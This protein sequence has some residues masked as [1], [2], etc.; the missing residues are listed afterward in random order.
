M[1]LN[2]QLAAVATLAGIALATLIFFTTLRAQAFAEDSNA[3]LGRL[4]RTVVRQLGP[5][6]LLFVVTL[7][8]LW[9]MWPLFTKSL[10]PL[11]LGQLGS[12]LPSMF[13]IVWLTG[14]LLCAYQAWILWRRL[15]PTLKS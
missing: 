4:N 13:S 7:L 14:A 9:A 8:T 11:R 12:A 5:D 6:L 2:D 10:H 3:G 1:L 15:K